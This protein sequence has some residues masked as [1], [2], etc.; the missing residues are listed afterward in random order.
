MH[1]SLVG[2]LSLPNIVFQLSKL[3]SFLLDN[4]SFAKAVLSNCS[5]SIFR[6]T[7]YMVGASIDSTTAF[8]LT[9]QNWAS[10]FLISWVSLCSVR[11][12]RISGWIPYSK[13]VFTECCVGLVF[14][15]PAAAK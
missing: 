8:I 15:S 9:L 2:F 11:H 12:T 14:N 10:F 1:T 13:S 7:S 6:G 4:F 3:G 5:L